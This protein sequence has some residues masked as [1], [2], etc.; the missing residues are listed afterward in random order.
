MRDWAWAGP[1]GTPGGGKQGGRT[2]SYQHWIL[3]R[4]IIIIRAFKIQTVSK[5]KIQSGRVPWV[6]FQFNT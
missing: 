1:G 2:K 6:L 5:F 4:K 3:R